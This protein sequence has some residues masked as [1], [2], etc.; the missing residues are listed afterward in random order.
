MK[1]RQRGL[2][3]LETCLTLGLVSIATGVWI[4]FSTNYRQRQVNTYNISLVPIYVDA[5]EHMLLTVSTDPLGLWTAKQDPQSKHIV[6]YPMKSHND[7]YQLAFRV[8]A[9]PQFSPNA[10]AITIFDP[11]GQK[12]FHYVKENLQ[13]VNVP[14]TSND[15]GK[16]ACKS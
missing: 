2:T 13:K 5:F 7:G 9:A 4:K 14:L 1:Y 16:Y 11:H 3:L 10:L 8:K 15:P 6:F 12:L